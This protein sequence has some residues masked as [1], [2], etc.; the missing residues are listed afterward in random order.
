VIVKK[1]KGVDMIDLTHQ[2]AIVNNA[3]LLPT[4]ME[5]IEQT[6]RSFKAMSHP[7]RLKILCILRNGERSVQG[8]VRMVDT[9]QSNVSQHLVIM[10]DEGILTARKDAKWVYYRVTD[11]RTLRLI[12]V[13]HDIFCRHRN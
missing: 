2:A 6:A 5:D 1:D 11:S 3:I 13:M 8:I 7:L 12:E 4:E 9:S 10:R